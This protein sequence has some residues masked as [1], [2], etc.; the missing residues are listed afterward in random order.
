MPGPRP[1]TMANTQKRN[2][3]GQKMINFPQ[4]T[5]EFMWRNYLINLY[6]KYW[7][8]IQPTLNALDCMV[9]ILEEK[10]SQMWKE[11]LSRCLTQDTPFPAGSVKVALDEK[12]SSLLEDL[13]RNVEY[14]RQGAE[15][16]IKVA[17]ASL[18]LNS[19]ILDYIEDA[20]QELGV[21]IVKLK[22]TDLVFVHRETNV[23][24]YKTSEE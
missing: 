4:Q 9:E 7:G 22:S 3:G 2:I 15:I 13:S 5:E 16:D 8:E 19:K 12:Q 17:K 21:Y 10:I 18:W 6:E 23:I 11:L 1:K 20:L 24:M 14:M